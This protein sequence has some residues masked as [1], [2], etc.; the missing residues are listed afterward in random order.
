MTN[1]NAGCLMAFQVDS[2]F[3]K[4]YV[5]IYVYNIWRFPKSWGV[6][7]NH[8]F[9]FGIFHETTHPAIGVAPVMETAE[10]LHHMPRQVA[11][12][13]RPLLAPCLGRQEMM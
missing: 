1:K 7:P 8:P 2:I 9:L 5:F 11:Q 4:I 10:I 3:T 13:C 6:P 12:G